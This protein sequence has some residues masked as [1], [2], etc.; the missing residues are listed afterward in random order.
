MNTECTECEKILEDAESGKINIKCLIMRNR[1]YILGIVIGAV[2]VYI[3]MRYK[4]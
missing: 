4:K 2:L 3:C 1:K